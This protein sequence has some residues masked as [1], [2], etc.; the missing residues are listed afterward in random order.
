MNIFASSDAT[1]VAILLLI[2]GIHKK[3]YIY[4]YIYILATQ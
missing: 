1:V 2:N 3:V 4:I